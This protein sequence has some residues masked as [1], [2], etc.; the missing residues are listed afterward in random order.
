MAMSLPELIAQAKAVSIDSDHDDEDSRI[1][2][3]PGRMD[4]VRHFKML[5]RTDAATLLRA[6]L[7]KILERSRGLTEDRSMVSVLLWAWPHPF[8]SFYASTDKE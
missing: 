3:L 7:T 8:G 2:S 6:D 5:G 1:K 4:S